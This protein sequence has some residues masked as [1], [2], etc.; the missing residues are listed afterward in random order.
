M[1]TTIRAVLAGHRASSFFPNSVSFFHSTPVL[2]RKRKNR[3]ARFNYYAKQK[4]NMESKRK[5][6]SNLSKYADHL[7]QR[8]RA[9]DEESFHE[10]PWF[11]R[12]FWAREARKNSFREAHW[13]SYRNKRNG[14]FEIC[15][16]DDD[17]IETIFGFAFGGAQF[18]NSSFNN[19][20]HFQQSSSGS[21]C[22]NS[23]RN[24]TY[25]TEDETDAD[26]SVQQSFAGERLALGLKATG[27]LKLKEVK[28]AYRSCALKWHPD[29]HQGSSKIAAEE[30][31]KCCSAAY[32]T[33]C[34]KLAMR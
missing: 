8:W 17:D 22:H 26:A 29:R 33:L 23:S 32:Q 25:E 14:A 5:L 13:R 12:H 27:P 3:H 19:S 34:D 18:S 28:N 24:W 4:R 21:T 7:T 30:K 10:I 20:E 15:P 6:V 16:S 2:E 11:R 9:E 31:F 1:N